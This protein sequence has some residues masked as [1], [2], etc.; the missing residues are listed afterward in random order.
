M[1]CCQLDSGP[2]PAVHRVREL[3]YINYMIKACWIRADAA[4][5]LYC[6]Q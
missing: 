5:P 1:W 4:A 2:T 3:N 6:D